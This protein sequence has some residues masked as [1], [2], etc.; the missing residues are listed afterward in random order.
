M[1]K[2]F[3]ILILL[4]VSLCCLP[5]SAKK[6]TPKKTDKIV[7]SVQDQQKLDY[8]FYEAI[9]QRQQNNYAQ[10]VDLLT[11]C[12]YIN[13]WNA[14]V[15]NEFS[16]IYT[17]L[18]DVPRAMQF[19][20]MATHLNPDN[21]WYKMGYAELCIKNNEFD[22]A[23]AVYEDIVRNHKEKE[24]VFYMLASLYRQ[25]GDLKKSIYYLDKVE[26][27]IGVNEEISFEK[28]RLYKALGKDKR[29]IAEIQKLIQ[30]HP[31]ELKYQ[32][33]LVGVYLEDKK[34]QQALNLLR[35][36]EQKN[37][38]SGPVAATLYAY[39]ITV[40]DSVSARNQFSKTMQDSL[41]DMD[42]KI[43]MLTQF[44]SQDNQSVADA[45]NYLQEL[46]SQYPE[47]ELLHSYYASFLLM[48]QR[49]QEAETELRK[50][51]QINPQNKESWTE[52]I[53]LYA[54]QDSTDQMIVTIDEAI[55]NFPEE[56]SF[57]YYRGLSYTYQKE[58]QKAIES[59]KT[60]LEKTTESDLPIIFLLTMSI[61]DLYAEIKNMDEA[62][63][64]YEKAYELDPNNVLLLNN[65]A[66]HLSLA[67][68]DLAKA[69][70]MSGKAVQAYPNEP[71]YLDTYAWVFFKQKNYVL[72][73]MYI[74]Q[75][76]DKGGQNNDVILEHCG[77]IFYFN[78]EVDDAVQYWQKSKEAGNQSPV[79]HQK[80]ESKSYI[81]E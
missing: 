56:N 67:G 7:I 42:D 30:K 70:E 20:L 13:P 53:K 47:N 2:N 11:E 27:K 65:F 79:L 8:Y 62:F 39:Y 51:I 66:Y 24:E 54:S 36:L 44:M 10:A 3:Y 41:I 33:L 22:K 75:A 21:S 59:Y 78:G 19:M 38:E 69:E 81:K 50:L 6:T 52:L 16:L 5:I 77:D 71:T 4:L 46:L 80:I 18:G 40:G 63:V 12:Y 74:L 37:P 61:A 23:I 26:D 60:G 72:A 34:P 14:A 58:Y 17:A 31:Y 64:Y 73:K 9:K 43:G 57:Y 55:K 15:A 28:Y 32:L 49:N 35:D 29:A 1:K 48:Q 68:K 76:I 45:E 25:T